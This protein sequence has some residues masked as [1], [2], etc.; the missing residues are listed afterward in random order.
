[1]WSM[2]FIYFSDMK[3][4]FTV[5]NNLGEMNGD[6]KSC[7]S[8]HRKEVGLHQDLKGSENGCQL[9]ETWNASYV[10]LLPDVLVKYDWNGKIVP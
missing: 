6:T 3:K 10:N 7:L 8:I 5:F 4:A 9:L 1:M 2:W